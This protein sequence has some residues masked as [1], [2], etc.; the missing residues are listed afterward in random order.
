MQTWNTIRTILCLIRSSIRSQ[1]KL[2]SREVIKWIWDK[3]VY[4]TLSGDPF[5]VLFLETRY[6]SQSFPYV[7][8]IFPATNHCLC[9]A[10]SNAALLLHFSPFRIFVLRVLTMLSWLL[11]SGQS[12]SVI[13]ERGSLWWVQSTIWGIGSQRSFSLGCNMIMLL[14]QGD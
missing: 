9:P 13:D 2:T 1:C 12:Q 7:Y 8:R 11:Q 4:P 10:K 3:R 14:L 6:Q 5:V